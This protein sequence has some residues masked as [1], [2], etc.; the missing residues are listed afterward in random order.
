[1][2]PTVEVRASRAGRVL[3]MLNEQIS[4]QQEKKMKETGVYQR[5]D[6]SD[7]QHLSVYKAIRY[8]CVDCTCNQRDLIRDCPD[9]GCPLWRFRFGV[10]PKT[11][12]SKGF[13][14]RG[15]RGGEGP[16][17]GRNSEGPLLLSA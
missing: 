14:V 8:F 16:Q 9:F 7:R 11:A 3:K 6:F 13:D 2:R 10:N 15:L 17:K 1:L 5:P 12:E 4:K